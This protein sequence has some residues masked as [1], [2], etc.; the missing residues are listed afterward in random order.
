MSLLRLPKNP[1]LKTRSND[2]HGLFQGKFFS[3][4]ETL[5]AHFSQGFL[6]EMLDFEFACCFYL[7]QREDIVCARTIFEL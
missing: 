6:D 1:R 3:A 4:P 7:F 5:L 2:R